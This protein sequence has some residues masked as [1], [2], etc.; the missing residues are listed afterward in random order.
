VQLSTDGGSTFTSIG[1]RYEGTELTY[2][3]ST[4]PLP[5]SVAGKTI[6]LRFHFQSDSSVSNPVHKGWYVDDVVVTGEPG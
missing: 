4:I 5:D 1:N 3:Q 2:S 6:K